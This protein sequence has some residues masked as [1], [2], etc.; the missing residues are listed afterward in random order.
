LKQT[1]HEYAIE[2]IRELTEKYNLPKLDCLD[3]IHAKFGKCGCFDYNTFFCHSTEA[4]ENW[5]IRALIA[6]KLGVLL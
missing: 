5:N 4:L 3:C 6:L 1:K 2:K